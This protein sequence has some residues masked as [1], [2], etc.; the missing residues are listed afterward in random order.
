MIAHT[1][2]LSVLCKSGYYLISFSKRK[3]PKD[4]VTTKMEQISTI[5]DQKSV[6]QLNTNNTSVVI[7]A[8][9]N[10]SSLDL[11]RKYPDQLI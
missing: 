3:H 9:D 11:V 5:Y 10:K 7:G 1:S 8:K 6:S 4:D 2:N